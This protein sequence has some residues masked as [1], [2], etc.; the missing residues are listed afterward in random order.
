MV[1]TPNWSN[2][3]GRGSGDDWYLRYPSPEHR[4]PIHNH[5]AD[6]IY[7]GGR[8][9]EAWLVIALAVVVSDGD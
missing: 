5:A 7:H 6:F 8:G 4:S 3:G 2:S 1:L 9:A